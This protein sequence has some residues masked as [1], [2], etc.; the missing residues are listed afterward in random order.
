M[1]I[2]LLFILLLIMIIII[3]GHSPLGHR[4]RT[5]KPGPRHLITRPDPGQI[6]A[7]SRPGPVWSPHGHTFGGGSPVHNS[8]YRSC[9]L[10]LS[11]HSPTAN[12]GGA[13]C[14]HRGHPQQNRCNMHKVSAPPHPDTHKGP[15]LA[16]TPQQLHTSQVSRVTPKSQG[17]L[18]APAQTL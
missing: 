7:R 12:Q 2:L 11:S 13:D 10:S 17:S 18:L 4:A 9:D 6:S 8:R 15:D 5:V 16:G 14:H 3:M 1:D